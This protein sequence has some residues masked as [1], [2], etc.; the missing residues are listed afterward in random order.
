MHIKYNYRRSF[1]SKI[2]LKMNKDQKTPQKIL[3]CP[4]KHQ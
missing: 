4:E 1:S 3:A 2:D